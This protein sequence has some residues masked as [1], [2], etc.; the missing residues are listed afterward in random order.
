MQFL[1][2][3]LL[4]FRRLCLFSFVICVL[5]EYDGSALESEERSRKKLHKNGAKRVTGSPTLD[6]ILS[7]ASQASRII[8]LSFLMNFVMKGIKGGIEGKGIVNTW[9][10]MV[11]APFKSSFLEYFPSLGE[12]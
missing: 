9:T 1:P 8:L 4:T 3:F 12:K 7:L 10:E 6:F 5:E 11:P 2:K